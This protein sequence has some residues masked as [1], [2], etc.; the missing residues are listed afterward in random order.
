MIKLRNGVTIPKLGLGTFK[1]TD[2]NNII[3]VITNALEIGYRHFDTAQM[4]ENE[5][6]IGIALKK[7][8]IDRNEIFI[9][10]KLKN[11]HN[12]ETTK[13]LILKSIKDLQIEYL[14]LLLIHWPNHDNNINLQTWRVFE[15]LYKEGL[16]RAI[17]VSNFTRY[18][19]EQLL[20][21][22]EI[23]PMVN[24]VEIHPGLSQEPLIEYL[25]K[26]DIVPISYGP[27]MRG[28]IFDSPYF[29]CL[30]E[31]AHKHNATVA[32]IAI[33]W[34]LNR[35]IVMIPKTETVSRLNENYL[36]KNIIL[37]SEDM[38]KIN[39]LNTGKRLYSDPSNNIYG[40]FIK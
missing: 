3:N 32:Q 23:K 24:Q 7:N 1:M 6:E 40:K 19:L 18:Q 29:D 25:L 37:D 5:K 12:P 17:G 28:L 14:D 36:A 35:N 15:E 9:T 30:S 22:C 27:L 20:P 21:H 11:H 38:E 33:A 2:A 13:Q 39:N 16:I 26:H 10:T 31:I 34:G 8:K 4:Y